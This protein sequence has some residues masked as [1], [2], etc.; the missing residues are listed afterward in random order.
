MQKRRPQRDGVVLLGGE[1]ALPTRKR[2]ILQASPA[3]RVRLAALIW[4]T[5]LMGARRG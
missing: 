4:G 5:Q 2:P 1:R 3:A